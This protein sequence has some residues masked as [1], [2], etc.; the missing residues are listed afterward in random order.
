MSEKPIVI[1]TGSLGRIGSALTQ[2]LLGSYRIIGFDVHK[3]APNQKDRE[4]LIVDVT[5]DESVE[6]AFLYIKK[7]YGTRIGSVVHLAAYYSFVDQ[8]YEKYQEIT[9][10]GTRRLLNALHGFDVKQFIFSST[11]LV[12][13]ACSIGEKITESSPLEKSWAYPRSKIETEELIHKERRNMPSMILRIAGVYD[14]MCHSIPISNQIQRIYEEQFVRFFFPGNIHSGA[15]F[16]HMDDLVRAIVLCIDK[17]ATLPKE[18]TLLLGEEKRPSIDELQRLISQLLFGEEMK[19]YRIPK[20]IAFL[21]SWAQCHTP[22]VQKPFI[23]PW[24][25]ALADQNYDILTTKAK[26]LLSFTTEKDVMRTLKKMI[27]FLQTDPESFYKV[28][29]LIPSKRVL[30]QWKTIKKNKDI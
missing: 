27:E 9:V 26:K 6:N 16:L 15:S 20:W 30:K 25:I 4:H 13:R 22:F 19:T 7:K 12:H 5:S 1:V 8:H 18:A 11:M 29:G 3:H 10:H 2:R 21:G 17:R 24:M 28:N 14:D 23:K